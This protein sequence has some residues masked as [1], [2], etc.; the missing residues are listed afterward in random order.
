[1]KHKKILVVDDSE[2]SLML[3]KM[4]LKKF[5]FDIV[6]ATDGREAVDQAIEERPDLILLDINMPGMNGFEALTIIRKTEGISHTPVIMV[7]SRGEE[8]NVQKGY[9]TG[10]DD[11]VIK[12]FSSV[13]LVEKIRELLKARNV[14]S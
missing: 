7:T 4:I 13:E 14:A 3:S 2:T 8:Q 9:D 11:F 1:M 6:T 12:P 5:S 10:A